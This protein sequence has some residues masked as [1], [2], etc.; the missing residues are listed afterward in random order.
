MFMMHCSYHGHIGIATLLFASTITSIITSKITSII[1][2]KITSKTFQGIFIFI[3]FTIL[4]PDVK[5]ELMMSLSRRRSSWS[6]N[7]AKVG[8]KAFRELA[9]TEENTE[10]R[11]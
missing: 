8:E 1:T 9:P 6:T 4:Q 2:Y 11:L 3:F 10:V 5:Q 7:T